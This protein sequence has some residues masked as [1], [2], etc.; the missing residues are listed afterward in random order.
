MIKN[1]INRLVRFILVTTMLVFLISCDGENN[2]VEE[3]PFETK[4]ETAENIFDSIPLRILIHSGKSTDYGIENTEAGLFS[5]LYMSNLE[6]QISKECEDKFGFSVEF[7]SV[8]RAGQIERNDYRLFF[9]SGEIADLIFPTKINPNVDHKNFW[10]DEF[11]DNGYYKDLTPY[12]GTYCPDVYLNMQRYDYIREMVTR[13]DKIYALYDGV[14]D[15]SC[16]ALQ[17]KNEL[18]TKAN[19]QYI[20]NFDELFA[21]MEAINQEEEPDE[22]NRILVSY[23]YL[24]KYA[25]IK[26]GFYSLASDNTIIGNDIV[27]KVDDPEC[28]PYFIEDTDILDV[29]FEEFLPFFKKSYFMYHSKTVGSLVMDQKLNYLSTYIDTNIRLTDQPF[30]NTYFNILYDGDGSGYTMKDYSVFLFDTDSVIVDSID[31]ILLIPVPKTSTQPEKALSFV[32]WLFTDEKMADYL[33]FGTDQG[34]L[35]NYQFNNDGNPVYNQAGC[36]VYLFH[37]LIANFSDRLIPFQNKAFDRTDEYKS[38]AE[39][40]NHPPLYR[41]MESK[42]AYDRY[43]AYFSILKESKLFQERYMYIMSVMA[44]LFSDSE[45]NINVEEIKDELRYMTDEEKI[46]SFLEERLQYIIE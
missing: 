13:D 7:L 34:K 12:L 37:N 11:V 27:F 42:H 40:A 25:T 30:S 44:E 28:K 6:G 19:T 43:F 10:M 9:E 4:L 5:T 1:R 23:Y 39:R 2:F 14:P 21:F 18:L 45:S 16:I 15:I 22:D 41:Y 46:I 29:F 38:L 24:L 31:S 33:T 3:T 17:V 32:N 20:H 8:K 36:P 26:A 35:P